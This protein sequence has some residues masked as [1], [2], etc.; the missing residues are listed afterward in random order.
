LKKLQERYRDVHFVII[1]EFSVVS[2]RMF[3]WIDQRMR[4]IWPQ[5]R[6]FPFG[7][8]DIIFTDDAGQ[9]DPV[10][11][12]ALSTPLEKIQ[13]EVQRKG[14]ELWEEIPYVC[15]LT[16]QNRGKSDPEWFNALRRL[17]SR[18][19]TSADVELL[20]SRCSSNT[21][22]PDWYTRA[23]HIAHK[24]IDVD[25]ANNESLL[26]NDTPIIYINALHHVQQKPETPN[27][28]RDRVVATKLM[29]CVGAPVTLTV[30]LEQSAGL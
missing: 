22:V 24:N 6:H 26:A 25:A 11:P 18:Q 8:R 12:Y 27:S 20:N 4:E 7:G 29:L 5:Q 23:K 21:P 30:N 3:H 2:C 10:V 17:R 9:L 28:D 16:D 1:D 14:R 13:N 15:M 19:P